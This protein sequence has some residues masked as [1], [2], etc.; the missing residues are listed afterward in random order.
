MPAQI[1]WLASGII[2][3]Q[4]PRTP[5]HVQSWNGAKGLMLSLEW[6]RVPREEVKRYARMARSM[7]ISARLEGG[8]PNSSDTAFNQAAGG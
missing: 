5:A 2:F 4:T 1:G 6:R 8:T 7:V 3:G